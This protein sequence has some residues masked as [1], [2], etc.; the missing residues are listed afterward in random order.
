MQKL[1]PFMKLSS[2]WNTAISIVL[3]FTAIVTQL[4]Q[5]LIVVIS[6]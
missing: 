2:F 1:N 4:P 6:L 5:I 3:A